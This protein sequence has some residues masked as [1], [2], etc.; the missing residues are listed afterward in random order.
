M[1]I[2]NKKPFEFPSFPFSLIQAI[3]SNY[4]NHVCES[5]IYSW[6]ASMK[7]FSFPNMFWNFLSCWKKSGSCLCNA[8]SGISSSGAES[9][10]QEQRSRWEK[11]RARGPSA[12]PTLS[13]CSWIIEQCCPSTCSSILSPLRVTGV[14]WSGWNM[15]NPLCVSCPTLR[16]ISALRI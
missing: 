13:G 15:R 2:Q 11:Q 14:R 5:V 7:S 4:Q 3:I 6:R 9:V 12:A 1:F 16:C 10:L 8:G